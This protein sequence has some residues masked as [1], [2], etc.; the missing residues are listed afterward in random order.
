MTR[1]LASHKEQ[2]G[3]V[4]VRTHKGRSK[5]CLDSPLKVSGRGV[6]YDDDT[7]G[8]RMIS[9]RRVEEAVETYDY[10]KRCSDEGLTA[11]QW[12]TCT[13]GDR[14]RVFPADASVAIGEGGGTLREAYHRYKAV[15]K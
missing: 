8:S 3:W 2:D 11:A 14:W 1:I 12:P 13:V 5:T 10:L 6:R 7:P 4:Y 9:S 15:A